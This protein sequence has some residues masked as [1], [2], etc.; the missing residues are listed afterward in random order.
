DRLIRL[1][2]GS[3][4]DDFMLDENK[5]NVDEILLDHQEEQI[6]QT[7]NEEKESLLNQHSESDYMAANSAVQ[8]IE[9]KAE[10]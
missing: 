3:I 9:N 8:P 6:E 5:N 2:N 4:I 1:K 7:S 10:S